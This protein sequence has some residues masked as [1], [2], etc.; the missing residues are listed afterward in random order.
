M[1]RFC[2]VL[3]FV[4]AAGIALATPGSPQQAE[5]RPLINSIRI[6]GPIEPAV[7]LYVH[8]GI[9]TAERNGAQALIVLLDTP[10]G[11]GDS[12]DSI[13][14]DFFASDVPIVVYV[15]PKGAK[16]ASAGAIITLASH[17]AAMSPATNIG[18]AHPVVMGGE[19]PDEVM[20]KKLEQDAAATARKIAHDR[21]RNMDVAEQFVRKSISLTED[22]AKEKKVIDIIARDQNDLLKQI[23]G[24]K[25]KMAG[26]E[27]VIR[28][29]NARVEKIEPSLREQFL[30]IVG[31]P[32]IAYILMLV[33]V[34][35]IIFELQNP[36]AVFPGVV[37]AISLILA[38]FSFAVLPVNLAGVLLIVLGIALL[39]A[40]VFIPGHGVLTIGGL[41]AF[42]VGSLILFETGSPVL[43]IS[44]TLII[45]MTAL[46]G[47]FFLFAVGAGIRGQRARIVTGAE[48]M[49]GQVAEARTDIDP[50]GKVFAEGSYWNALAEGG[51]IKKGE[52]VRVI[53]VEKLL[54]KVKKESSDKP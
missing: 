48:G 15:W 6:E 34:Y 14:K 22:E 4:V 43:R 46:T 16:A 39:V 30:H 53:G 1:K 24:R 9:G 42:V 35:G 21:G 32:N 10:G 41:I 20:S 50:K 8:R 36:G 45:T 18:A 47:G 37:G 3:A 23:D 44:L 28:S 29:R 7:A 25:V 11:L 51:P 54:L 52:P 27:T 31:N 26:G 12:M 33:A 40:D 49:I 19:Q 5:T 13:V 17:I 2:A 38:L